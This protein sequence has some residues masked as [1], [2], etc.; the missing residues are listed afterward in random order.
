[1][2]GG[3][4][5]EAETQPPLQKLSPQSETTVYVDSDQDP[6]ERTPVFVARETA[7]QALNTIVQVHFEKTLEK[8]RSVDLQKKEL[9]KMFQFFFL[10]LA[11]VFA[12]V[13][14]STKLQCRHVWMP[15]MLY[16]L[17]HAIFYVAMAQTLRCINGFK[18]QRR[19]HK[20][21]LG[22]A[23]EKL[24]GLKV[25]SGE[26]VPEDEF[27]VRYQE[28]G[29]GYFNKFRRKWALFAVFLML[30]FFTMVASVV[31]LLCN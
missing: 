13:V 29:D 14:Q 31:T 15:I 25:S 23:T 4:K 19:C 11:I 7:L 10:F 6:S 9:W 8:K 16:G 30:T 26:N 22:L 27:E 5:R 20:L 3:R 2:E 17:G 1:M 28:P 21:T 18:Y 12:S 24:K